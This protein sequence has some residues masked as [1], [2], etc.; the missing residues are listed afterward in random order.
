MQNFL[1]SSTATLL[2]SG[3][4]FIAAMVSVFAAYFSAS[5]R[6]KQSVVS[7][8]LKQLSNLIYQVV[9][10]S[11]KAAR[12]G[13][14]DNFST[15]IEKA[16][17]VASELDVLKR[18]HRYSLPFIVD[19]IWYLKGIPLYIAHYRNDLENKRVELLLRDATKL[20]E[21]IDA[22]LVRYFYKG[23]APGMFA[24]WQLRRACLKLE[25][26]FKK[27]KETPAA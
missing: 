3:L 20:R 6:T 15:R 17:K 2:A 9:A 18:S 13:D 27:G 22:A 14:I 10:L 5:L 7:E 21:K 25:N 11:A 23:I 19:P 8:D 1:D 4:A 16:T 12:S 24:K 26:T